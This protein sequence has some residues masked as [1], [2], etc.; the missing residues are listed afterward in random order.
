[1]IIRVSSDGSQDFLTIDKALNKAQNY[2]TIHIYPGK[3]KEQLYVNK[4]I[5]LIGIGN[6]KDIIIFDTNSKYDNK[7]LT[8][9]TQYH[10]GKFAVIR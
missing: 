4:E 2:D 7:R 6:L 10:I 8:K 1:M 9:K 5:Q 3:Y